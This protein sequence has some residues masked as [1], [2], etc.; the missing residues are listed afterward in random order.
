M[1]FNKDGSLTIMAPQ[2]GV[3]QGPFVGFGDVRNLD[4]YSEPGVVQLN[5]IM[6]KKSG[7]TVV[8]Q[9]NWIVRHPITT[10]EIYAL[11]AAGT[12]YKS[13]DTGATW[14]VLSG[15]SATNAHGNGLWIWKNYLFVARDAL[16]DV[17]GDGSATGIT[18]GNFTL[19][20][21]TIDSDVLWHPMMTSR[22][23]NKLYGGAGIYVYSL[24]EVSGQ[25]FAPGNGATYTWTQQALDL[26]PAY[27]IKCIEELGNNLMLGTWQG[28]NIYDIRIANIFPWDRSS[29][30]FG[31]PIVMAEFGIHAMLN[32]GNQLIVL[33]GIEG[34]IFRSDG[35]NAYPIGQLPMDLSGGKYLEWYP[36]ALVAF[37]NKIFFGVGQGGTTAIPAMGVYS[38]YQTGRGNILTFEHTISTLSDGTSNPLKPSALLPVTRDSMLIAW[39]D[40]ATY[41]IDLTTNTSYAYTTNYSGFFDSPLYV[42]GSIKNLRT[43][44][45]IEFELGKK[46]AT[47]EGI[48]LSYRLNS[49]DSFTTIGTYTFANLGTGAV[50]SHFDIPGIPACELLQIRVALLGTST[51]TPQLKSV[52]LR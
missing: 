16:L 44:E 19:G 31:Q 17:C 26:P 52:T 24:D 8:A 48:Q 23:D 14:A 3:A 13:T 4:I 22:N 43:F 36:G 47:G 7:S 29:T 42:V 1:A 9:V 27:R 18:A 10:T 41:G 35:V 25:T 34:T 49:T 39:R 21:K 30:S 46:L 38:L 37:K 33:A 32:I 15:T 12:V 20:W 11:D 40:N 51:T 5:N 45:F 28:T 2:Q 50:L 6:V